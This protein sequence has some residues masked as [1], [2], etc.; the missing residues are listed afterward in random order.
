M[1]AAGTLNK[2]G[3][4]TISHGLLGESLPAQGE[5]Q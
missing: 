4:V 1:G 3:E 2:P 5:P